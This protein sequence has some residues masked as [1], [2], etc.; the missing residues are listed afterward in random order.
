[1][2]NDPLYG[3]ISFN[4]S[5]SNAFKLKLEHNVKQSLVEMNAA[6]GNDIA[7]HVMRPAKIIPSSLFK[8]IYAHC[9]TKYLDFGGIRW[10]WKPGG[11]GGMWVWDW[12]Y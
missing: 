11:W 6:T 7:E 2:M 5:S 1:M 12:Q 10:K 8:V 4:S 9:S 3:Q